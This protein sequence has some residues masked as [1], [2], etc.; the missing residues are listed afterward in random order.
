MVSEPFYNGGTR[1]E[2]IDMNFMQIYLQKLMQSWY[3]ESIYHYQDVLDTKLKNINDY[4]NYLKDKKDY[5]KEIIDSLT[6]EL[7][8]KYIDMMEQ[9]QI[10][11]AENLS[12]QDIESMK[13]HLNEIEADYA[14]LEDHLS[15]QNRRKLT[16][17]QE[18]DLLERIAV[19]S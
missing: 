1:L 4:I 19:V 7:E 8:N 18:C 11:Y 6:I 13:H 12:G 10:R 17:E 16:M 15:E 14:R 9:H 5:I 2:V 3:Q